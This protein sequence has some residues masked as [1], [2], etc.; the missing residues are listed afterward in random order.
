MAQIAPPRS[1]PAP[2]TFRE[3][4]RDELEYFAQMV[5]DA[6]YTVCDD[7]GEF[8]DSD[9]EWDS[10]TCSAIVDTVDELGMLPASRLPRPA[11]VD[12]PE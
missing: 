1:A 4:S 3:L 9:K 12:C 6:L 7:E 11:P 5:M 2:R 8:Y 10:E